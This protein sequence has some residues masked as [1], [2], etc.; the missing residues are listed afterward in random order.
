MTTA[1]AIDS[2]S[3]AKVWS[4]L[5]L[6]TPDFVAGSRVCPNNMLHKLTTVCIHHDRFGLTDGHI[7]NI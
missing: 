1:W 3:L 7:Y 5:K 6:T 4:G 2:P